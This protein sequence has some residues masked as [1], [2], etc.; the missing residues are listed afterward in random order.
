[1]Q[2]SLACA[3]LSGP[4][5]FF[6]ILCDDVVKNGILKT[7]GS[8]GLV[9]ATAQGCGSAFMVQNLEQSGMNLTVTFRPLHAGSRLRNRDNKRISPIRTMIDQS[10]ACPPAHP[11]QSGH[12]DF[13]FVELAKIAKTSPVP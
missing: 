8:S 6:T 11:F 7:L 12:E 1:M 5:K 13:R 9:L 2:Q 4:G 3:S 10:S